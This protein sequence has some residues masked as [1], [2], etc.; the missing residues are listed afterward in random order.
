LLL[1]PMIP[2]YPQ[3]K[4]IEGHF[5]LQNSEIE[6]WCWAWKII[7]LFI[8]IDSSKTKFSNS[9]V[10]RELVFNYFLS[11][12]DC[13]TSPPVIKYFPTLLNFFSMNSWWSFFPQF[14]KRCSFQFYCLFDLTKCF[15]SIS[16]KIHFYEANSFGFY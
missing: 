3:S 9:Q 6:T 7:V 4:V 10:Y 14:S 11:P 13:V 2:N 8:S 5:F 15:L 12:P 16:G 1:Q